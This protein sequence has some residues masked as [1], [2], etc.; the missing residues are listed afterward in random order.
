MSWTVVLR[1]EV[2]RWTSLPSCNCRVAVRGDRAPVLSV[3]GVL[4]LVL[5]ARSVVCF[6]PCPCLA[7]CGP[8]APTAARAPTGT[9]WGVV[10]PE[11]GGDRGGATTTCRGQGRRSWARGRAAA[12]ARRPPALRVPRAPY[13]LARGCGFCLDALRDFRRV[14]ERR[15][16]FHKRKLASERVR[17][18]ERREPSRAS[19]G[20]GMERMAR[21]EIYTFK[22]KGNI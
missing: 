10:T 19:E 6:S 16:L 9:W 13:P 5:Q 3:R 11:H 4:C 20:A 21:F 22:G 14:D 2:V 17:D 7:S 18:G 12:R 1:G 15:K 8:C